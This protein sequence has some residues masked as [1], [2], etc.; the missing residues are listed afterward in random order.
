MFA[1]KTM[2]TIMIV[3]NDLIEKMKIRAL[4][5]F[6]INTIIKFI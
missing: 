2:K 4:F 1:L 5:N 3:R 6:K